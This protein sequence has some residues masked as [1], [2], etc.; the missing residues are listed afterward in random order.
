GAVRPRSAPGLDRLG[1][2]D[3]QV[4]GG[5]VMF[6][7]DPRDM[8]EA[9]ALPHNLE[10]EQD[11]L[12]ALLYDN[13]VVERISDR[14]RGAHFYEPFH[15]RLFDAILQASAAGRSASPTLL[16][17][18]FSGDEAFNQFGGLAYLNQL[19]ERAPP[20]RVAVDFSRAIYDLAV[21]RDL[22]R[23][24]GEIAK[25]AEDTSVPAAEH[26]AKAEGALFALAETGE[27]GKGVATF[28]E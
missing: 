21:R 4:R 24:G 10:A 5:C 20:V 26:L 18:T 6:D 3:R 15:Q 28:A 25:E 12:G 2:R 9:K 23:I 16:A 13:A 7:G 27:Q 22:I 19:V 14:L 1:Q 11:L 17:T 8:A